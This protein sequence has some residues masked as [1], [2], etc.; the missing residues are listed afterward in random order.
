MAKNQQELDALLH[1]LKGVSQSMHL[2]IVD[3]KFAPN[4]SLN[5]IF[6]LPKKF[7]Y[8]VH[9]MIKDPETWIKTHPGFE[10][11]FPQFE[12]VKNKEKFIAGMKKSKKKIGIFLV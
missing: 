11:Y 4:Q 7:K 8:N 5:F 1:K 10:L 6:K 2:D 12:T 9:L 3:G